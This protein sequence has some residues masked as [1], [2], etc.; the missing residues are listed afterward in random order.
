MDYFEKLL[1]NIRIKASVYFTGDICGSH[2]FENH[3]IES[4]LHLIN[5]G[6]AT[7]TNPK[8]QEIPINKP[9]IIFLPKSFK[10]QLVVRD[11]TTATVICGTLKLGIS[12]NNPITTSLP[13]LIIVPLNELNGI[14]K[15]IDLIFIESFLEGNSKQAV[16]NRL[17]EIL[18]IKL[19]S[20]CSTECFTSR[21]VLAGLN[22]PRIAKAL[23]AIHSNPAEPWTV[24]RLAYESNLSRAH[25]SNLFHQIVGNTPLKYLTIWRLLMAQE[26]L[27]QGISLE[28]T[29]SGVGYSSASALTRTFSKHVGVSP[30]QWLK[31]ATENSQ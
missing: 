21:G 18:I 29:A 24:E 13:D 2:D 5:N 12:G 28:Q 11:H 25:F 27:S 14:D 10:H 23:H 30:I 15:F 1:S 22:E 31:L 3:E 4:H 9:S 6:F 8:G 7:I 19:L 17:C 16:Q 20:F 26:F